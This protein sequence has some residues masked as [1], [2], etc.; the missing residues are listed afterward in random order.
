MRPLS[1]TRMAQW[2]GFLAASAGLV[3][4]RPR[5][6]VLHSVLPKSLWSNAPE[7]MPITPS[8]LQRLIV[9]LRNHGYEFVSLDEIMPSVVAQRRDRLVSLTFDDAL[10]S[11][12]DY[13]VPILL[14]AEVP[15]TLFVCSD[16]ARTGKSLPGFPMGSKEHTLTWHDLETL[17]S[18]I[19][20]GS[21][22]ASHVDLAR[23]SPDAQQEM[24]R[25]SYQQLSRLASFRPYV[26]F[27]FGLYSL[28]T[29]E[30]ARLAGFRAGFSVSPG[31]SRVKQGQPSVVVGRSL[32][33]GS[34]RRAL[35]LALG[36]LDIASTAIRRQS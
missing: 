11:F 35:A 32:V 3:L 26:A 21:H 24:L 27:P 20:I 2:A 23:S 13:A 18:E 30:A 1:Q 19:S 22:G 4:R 31:W 33:A 12:R 9:G 5:V 36:G 6:L 14:E 17:P 34:D 25:R 28:A 7:G 16:H 8:G 10:H 15:A 29:V